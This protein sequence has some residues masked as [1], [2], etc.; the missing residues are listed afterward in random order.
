MKFGKYYAQNKDP[1][2]SIFYINYKKLK[3]ILKKNNDSEVFYLILDLEIEKLENFC[4]K[5]DDENYSKNEISNFLVI[6]YMALF[7][8]V[9]KHDKKL[10]RFTK[11]NFFLIGYKKLNFIIII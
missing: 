10:C 6:N 2:F 4:N 8:A 3:K 11:I 9:K 7:K 5:L 1:K